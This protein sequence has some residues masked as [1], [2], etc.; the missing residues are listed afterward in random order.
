[1][2]D[3]IKMTEDHESYLDGVRDS[4]V[5]NMFEASA[6]LMQEFP[7]L[8]KK[9]AQSVLKQWMEKKNREAMQ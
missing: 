5:M 1:M 8:S 7:E 2:T 4:G 6:A 3:E 9:E